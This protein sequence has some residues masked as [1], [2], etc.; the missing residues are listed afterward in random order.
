[1]WSIIKSFQ[2]NVNYDITKRR[3]DKLNAEWEKAQTFHST[4]DYEAIKEE[5]KTL[6]YFIQDHY[7]KAEDA[8]EEA[9]DF[10]VT[11]LNK[12]NKTSTSVHED[13]TN[14]LFL[15]ATK[16]SLSQLP[17]ID[18]PKFSGV[19]SE[20]EGFRNT[21]SDMVDS[22]KRITNTLVSLLKIVR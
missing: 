19:I 3:L 14:S 4:I 6:S 5:R 17:C 9:A 21:F 13:A 18:L 22:N 15:D 2:A 7:L 10:L 11:D 20:W 12:F 16:P 1:L 8:Y